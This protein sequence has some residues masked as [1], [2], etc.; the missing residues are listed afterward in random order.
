MGLNLFE[1]AEKIIME[2]V[3]KENIK[4]YIAKALEY[5]Q[6]H[7]TEAPAPPSR[8]PGTI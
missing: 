6:E 3:E 7:D 4:K 1:E 2:N 8:P 5:L